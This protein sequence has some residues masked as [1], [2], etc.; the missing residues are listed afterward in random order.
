MNT[1]KTLLILIVT[2][3][4]IGLGSP[5]ASAGSKQ[6]HRWEGVAIGLG[7]A[8]IGHAIY[9]GAHPGSRPQVVHDRPGSKFCR[10]QGRPHHHGRWAWQKIWVPPT[11]ERV[12]NPGHYNPSG[13]WV[14]GN[15]IEVVTQNG[16]WSRQRVRIADHPCRR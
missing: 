7:A 6:R 12:W 4:T 15:W 16:Y 11:T 5:F 2:L 8:I 1:K 9:Q 13:C 10:H 14:K 3:L